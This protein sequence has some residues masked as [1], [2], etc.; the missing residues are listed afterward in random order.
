ML[1]I[2]DNNNFRLCNKRKSTH[3]NSVTNNHQLQ[4]RHC[5]DTCIPSEF[6][7]LLIII[8]IV[9][10]VQARSSYIT[11]TLPKLILNEWKMNFQHVN[12]RGVCVYL[13]SKRGISSNLP[14]KRCGSFQEKNEVEHIVSNITLILMCSV[15][16]MPS[17]YIFC[18]VQMALSHL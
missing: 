13:Y 12:I 18:I 5:S 9:C 7:Q 11:C 1:Q 15:I 14:G 10:Y 4:G 6:L 8:L 2:S 3:N 17:N 16:N